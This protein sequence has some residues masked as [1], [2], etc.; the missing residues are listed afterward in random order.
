MLG[1]TSDPEIYM[2]LALDGF[3]ISPKGLGLAQLEIIPE[4]YTISPD[5]FTSGIKVDIY[6]K[7]YTKES[8]VLAK[9]SGLL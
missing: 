8:I 4:S 2:D 6:A 9:L 1:D 3:K 7:N 5:P